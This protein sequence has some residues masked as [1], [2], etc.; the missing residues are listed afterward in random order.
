MSLPY[1]DRNTCLTVIFRKTF[2][3]NQRDLQFP[4][5]ND[6]AT[7]NTYDWHLTTSNPQH[8]TYPVQEE[9]MHKVS[10]QFRVDI[11]NYSKSGQYHKLQKKKSLV[12]E[13]RILGTLI[14]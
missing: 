14:L 10:I 11:P 9:P 4:T 1:N 7:T 5:A 13:Q 6:M 3:I 2:N 8:L 12:T